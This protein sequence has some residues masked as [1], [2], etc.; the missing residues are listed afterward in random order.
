MQLPQASLEEKHAHQI[1]HRMF[2]EMRSRGLSLKRAF[3][4]MQ[5]GDYDPGKVGSNDD[6]EDD[7]D[8]D[9][10]E[11]EEEEYDEQQATGTPE[12]AIHQLSSSNPAS[13]AIPS[14]TDGSAPPILR[15]QPSLP[16][17]LSP[18]WI[19]CTCALQAGE[20]LRRTANSPLLHLC[21]SPLTSVAIVLCRG[22]SCKAD[23]ITLHVHRV[24]QRAGC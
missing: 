2:T 14:S 9:E 22:A 1:V 15:R 24:G 4:Q 8:D 12:Q 23:Q 18:G 10:E 7:D 16:R 11:D 6:S 13:A 21:F 19:T 3:E 5:S 20:C 17:P